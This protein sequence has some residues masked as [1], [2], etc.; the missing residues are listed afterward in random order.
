MTHRGGHWDDKEPNYPRGYAFIQDQTPAAWPVYTAAVSWDGAPKLDL[1]WESG[2]NTCGHC[3]P[4]TAVPMGAAG[5]SGDIGLTYNMALFTG[6]PHIA[7]ASTKVD[8]GC[9]G[10]TYNFRRELV[11]HEMGHAI[12]LGHRP[13]GAGSCMRDGNAFSTMGG[14]VVG[15]DPDF[16]LLNQ[17]YG[18]GS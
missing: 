16:T 7:R 13:A 10:Q 8:S 14:Q 9:A 5:C 4:F 2:S 6:T 3:V 1:V 12:G 17:Q 11:C 18:H 15:A